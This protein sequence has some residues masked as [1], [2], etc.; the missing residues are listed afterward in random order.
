MQVWDYVQTTTGLALGMKEVGLINKYVV[1]KWG[2]RNGLPLA[3][4]LEA[5]AVIVITGVILTF[6]GMTGGTVFSACFGAFELF[7]NIRSY[8]LLKKK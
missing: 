8:K 5:A 2:A 6:A 1:A 3:T 4:F 7:N